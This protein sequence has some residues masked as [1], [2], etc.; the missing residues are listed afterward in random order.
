MKKNS[1]DFPFTPFMKKLI[2]FSLLLSQAYAQQVQVQGEPQSMVKWMTLEEAQKEQK[3][4]P[5]PLLI[6]F[7]TDWCGWCKRMMMTTYSNPDFAA[8]I[9]QW[10]YPVKFNAETRDSVYYRDTLFVNRS[11]G[12]RATHDFAIRMLGQRL[13]YPTTV[14]VT[15]DFQQL[16]APG[17][18]EVKDMEPLLVYVVENIFRYAPYEDFKNTFQTAFRE[19]N[20]AIPPASL[21][22]EQYAGLQKDTLKKT[23]VFLFTNWCI[24][25]RAMQ[26]AVFT[27]TAVA[28]L[29]NEHF[30]LIYLDA[31]SRMPLTWNG[32]TYPADNAS[33]PFHPVI[34]E[35]TG[36][37][38]Q[39]PSLLVFDEKLQRLDN[40]NYFTTAAHLKKVLAYFGENHYRKVTWQQ[41]LENK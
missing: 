7:Y 15:S 35:L 4:I 20:S 36:G 31:E 5:K 6:D 40:L 28:R 41:F 14:F 9:N 10:F 38:M 24:S 12:A 21:S 18:M 37:G 17:Y 8:Y 34:K 39:L 16:V 1:I 25:C 3:K 33:G 22:F 26:L 13:S 29:I 32:K 23:L 2:L 27:D 11:E 30:Y 19:N